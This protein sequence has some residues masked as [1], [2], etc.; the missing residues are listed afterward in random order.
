MNTTNVKSSDRIRSMILLHVLIQDK[1]K[2]SHKSTI[3]KPT[4]NKITEI[5]QIKQ[6]KPIRTNLAENIPK[7]HINKCRAQESESSVTTV[8]KQAARNVRSRYTLI[9]RLQLTR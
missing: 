6:N 5:I 9:L 1:E 4:R 8:F 7:L 3:E 2:S